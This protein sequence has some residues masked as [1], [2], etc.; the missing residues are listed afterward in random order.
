MV[1]RSFAISLA[2]LVSPPPETVTVFVTLAG[3]LPATLT[4]STIPGQKAAAAKESLRVQLVVA[5]VQVHP[6]PER[7]VAVK[8]GGSESDTFTV[9]LV[10]PV[11]PLPTVIV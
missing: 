5:R 10:G 8:L 7:A 3:A 4:V 9:P 1:V 6:V 2:V 11:P